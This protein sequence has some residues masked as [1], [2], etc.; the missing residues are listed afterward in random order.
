[1]QFGEQNCICG[2]HYMCLDCNNFAGETDIRL[3]ADCM[4]HYNVEKLWQLHDANELEALD[5]NESQAMRD[6]FRK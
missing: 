4:Q 1:M 2:Y 6:Q 5:F 3:C